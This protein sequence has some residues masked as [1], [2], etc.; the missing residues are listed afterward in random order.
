MH[1]DEDLQVVELCVHNEDFT[2]V[3]QALIELEGVDIEKPVPSRDATLAE[4]V[5]TL[6][7]QATVLVTE[8]IKLKA[9][10]E[11]KERPIQV[12]V[13]T[14]DGTEISLQDADQEL[15]RSLLEDPKQ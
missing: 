5:L 7:A 13:Y 1:S 15:L 3:E 8:L 6:A 14:E 9:A 10:L 4:V 2:V 12:V 11:Q